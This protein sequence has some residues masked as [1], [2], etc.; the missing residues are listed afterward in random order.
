MTRRDAVLGG[1]ALAVAPKIAS[2][3]SE[4]IGGPAFGSTWRLV[5]ATSAPWAV[6]L[7]TARIAATDAAMS[8]Y[9]STSALSRFNR[10]GAGEDVTI[11]EHMAHVVRAALQVSHDTL[12]AFDPTTGPLVARFGYGP[13]VGNMGR[14]EDIG[15]RGTSL[16]K[17]APGLTLDL[18]GIAKGYALD[19][20]TED[21]IAQGATDFLLELGG[22]VR[23]VGAHPTGRAWHVAIEDPLA[24]DFAAHTI[25]APGPL[26]LTTSGHSANGLMG[27]IATSHVIAP[28]IA[29]PATGFAASVSVLG[30]T[31][32]QADAMATALLAMGEGGPDFARGHD[33]A[34]LFIL[35]EPRST[36]ITTGQFNAHIIA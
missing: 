15:L 27:D 34:A 36:S 29:R 25:V 32:M 12:G 22:E 14:V 18:C 8:P 2:A 26:A 33:I 21:L 28:R 16:R 13:I 6:P 24:T 4:V 11:D 30:E 31:G 3:H 19:C 35:A 1:M 17:T 7:I 23:T 9:R 20:M 5:T 10:A